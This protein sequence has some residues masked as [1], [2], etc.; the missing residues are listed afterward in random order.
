MAHRALRPRLLVALRLAPSDGD[1]SALKEKSKVSGVTEGHLPEALFIWWFRFI[2]QYECCGD[3][4]RASAS[5]RP[6]CC[7]NSLND[8]RQIP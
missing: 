5:A 6:E 2:N 8:L 7:S 3:L 1:V 4:P